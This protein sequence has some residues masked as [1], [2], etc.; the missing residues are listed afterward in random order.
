MMFAPPSPTISIKN[1]RTPY[2][3]VLALSF[4]SSAGAFIVTPGRRSP[5]IFGR[6]H[7][8]IRMGSGDG[9]GPGKN[10][11]WTSDD[12]FVGKQKRGLGPQKMGVPSKPSKGGQSPSRPL[13]KKQ[14]KL[15][16]LEKQRT[17]GGSVDSN[18][19]PGRAPADQSVQVQ[20]GKRGS[21]VVTMVRG[22]ACDAV[23]RAGMLK[24]L[25]KKLGGGGT[26]VEGVIE[27]QGDHAEKVLA[28][29]RGR[30]YTKSKIVGGKKKK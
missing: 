24:E 28:Y 17:A 22:L 27:V 21:K 5:A 20:A 26:L 1:S 13:S 30:G 9:L 6:I 12:G 29:L 11:V 25:K 15:Q 18:T 3:F 23:E 4:V 19:D 14:A 2:L 10:L 16:R 7:G 8:S